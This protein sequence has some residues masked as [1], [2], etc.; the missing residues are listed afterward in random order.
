[1]RAH[2]RVVAGGALQRALQLALLQHQRIHLLAQLLYL[3]LV[4]LCFLLRG[5]NRRP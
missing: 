2:L 4:R 1:M 5:A 3:L